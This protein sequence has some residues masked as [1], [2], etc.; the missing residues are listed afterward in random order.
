MEEGGCYYL[1]LEM[2]NSTKTPFDMLESTQINRT[3]R[4]D[5]SHGYFGKQNVWRDSLNLW[6]LCSEPTLCDTGAQTL[7]IMILLCQLAPWDISSMLRMWRAEEGRTGSILSAS[8]RIS[9]PTRVT[10]ASFLHHTVRAAG[11]VYSFPKTYRIYLIVFL[12]P[13]DLGP[14]NPSPAQRKQP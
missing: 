13:E 14:T 8:C 3:G 12:V 7:P 1:S 4:L 10:L 6:S 5:R 2:P 9:A 11:A